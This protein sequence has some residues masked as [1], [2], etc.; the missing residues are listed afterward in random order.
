MLP[1]GPTSSHLS[2]KELIQLYFGAFQLIL[3]IYHEHTSD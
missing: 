2:F 1:S 3:F